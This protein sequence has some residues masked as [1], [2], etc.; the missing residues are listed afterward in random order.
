MKRIFLTLAFIAA[1]Q[2]TFAQ[3]KTDDAQQPASEQMAQLRLAADLAKYGYETYSASALIEAARILSGVPTHELTPESLVKGEG[4]ADDKAQKAEFSVEQLL[5]DG[6][7][8]ADGDATLLA[9]ADQVKVDNGVSRGR[10]EGSTVHADCVNANATDTYTLRFIGGE[11]AEVAVIGDGDTDLD[12][13]IYDSNG[14]LIEK[15]DDYTDRCY[16]SWTPK[17]TGAFSV[18]IKNRG[19]VCNYYTLYTN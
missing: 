2:F 6:R 12:L 11:L 16:C 7:K 18:K 8:Y 10:V 5:E 14:N 9:L 3:E 4:A 13:Y 1:A 15:D 19:G 17:W